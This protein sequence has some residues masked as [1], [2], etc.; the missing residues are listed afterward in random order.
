LKA[1]YPDIIYIFSAYNENNGYTDHTSID[2][3][4]SV[5]TEPRSSSKASTHSTTG[6]PPTISFTNVTIFVGEYSVY[7]FDELLRAP[8]DA[9]VQQYHA[10]VS[11]LE[12]DA[13]PTTD[14]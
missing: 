8:F 3:Q 12:F 11:C 9:S 5:Q 6:K 4:T 14:Y 2:P 10:P 7:G 13:R 1:K